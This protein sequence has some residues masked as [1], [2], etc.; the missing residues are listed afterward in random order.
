MWLQC[1]EI[2]CISKKTFSFL[3]RSQYNLYTNCINV[4]CYRLSLVIPVYRHFRILTTKVSFGWG[5]GQ[6]YRT[7]VKHPAMD[8]YLAFYVDCS[9]L[10][11]GGNGMGWFR[12]Q[13]KYGDI[14]VFTSS[15]YNV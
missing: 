2:L 13:T 9:L 6:I 1:S 5:S 15:T 12:P 8:R 11:S 3:R 14:V 4:E 10:Y 7:P